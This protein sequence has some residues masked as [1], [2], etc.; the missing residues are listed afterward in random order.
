MSFIEELSILYTSI[1]YPKVSIIVFRF[2]INFFILILSELIFNIVLQYYGTT[3][4]ALLLQSICKICISELARKDKSEF[5]EHVRIA[6]S[7]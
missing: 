5:S 6:F 3:L 4:I 2:F 7:A 1:S